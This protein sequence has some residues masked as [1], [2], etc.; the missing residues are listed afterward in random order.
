MIAARRRDALTAGAEE[1]NAVH[2]FI[3]V[4]QTAHIG[5]RRN[6]PVSGE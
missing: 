6:L 5:W 4:R 3:S 2:A 1:P